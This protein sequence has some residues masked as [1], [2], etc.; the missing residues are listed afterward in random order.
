MAK[1]FMPRKG[2][3]RRPV[4]PAEPLYRFTRD[5]FV[6][7]QD[8]AAARVAEALHHLGMADDVGEEDGAEAGGR[9]VRLASR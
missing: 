6:L 2:R 5:P 4:R 1:M 3:P 7:A 8:L 9:A